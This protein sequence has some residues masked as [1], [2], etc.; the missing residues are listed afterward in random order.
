[1]DRAARRLVALGAT[2]AILFVVTA[3]AR[4]MW[5]RLTTEGQDDWYRARYEVPESL[6]L[7]SGEWRRLDVTVHNDGRL[8][9]RSDAEQPFRLSYHWLTEDGLRVLQFDGLRTPFPRAV[10]PGESVALAA[11][12]RA[13]ARA[14]RYQLAWDV[15]QE[16]R[17]WFS[18]DTDDSPSAI[19]RV[20]TS[21]TPAD[22]V[23]APP[24]KATPLPGRPVRPGRLVLWRLAIG[25]FTAHPLLG[26]GPDNFR[27]IY[28]AAAGLERADPRVHTNNMY[29]E[30]FV[31]A[32]VLGGALLLWLLWR[33]AI[34]MVRAWP[35]LGGPRPVAALGVAAALIAVLAHGLVDSFLTFTPTYILIWTTLGLAVRCAGDLAS[36]PG[37]SKDQDHADRV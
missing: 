21:G 14:G 31:G 1:M 9:W 33:A 17:L 28:G 13:P 37:A 30:L 27:L 22:G 24:W 26:V 6:R 7:R 36:A 8:I 5:L 19:T 12:V 4:P 29:L 3:W 16:Q 10:A 18:T 25:M 32:G 2:I 15:V 35:V 20:E 11:W 34:G 23:A